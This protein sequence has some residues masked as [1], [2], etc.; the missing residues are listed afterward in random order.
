[1]ELLKKADDLSPFRHGIFQVESREL[2]DVNHSVKFELQPDN[3]HIKLHIKS[4]LLEEDN[5]ELL[6]KGSVLILFISEKFEIGKPLYVHHVKR[7]LFEHNGYER[8]RSCK[9]ELPNGDYKIE[10][11]IWNK[12]K[13]R[14]EI[15]LGKNDNNSVFNNRYKIIRREQ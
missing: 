13:N 11:T 8:L 1:M 2:M 14:L 3:E 12:N 6:L 15:S 4:H 7:N 9:Y 5:F 10:R